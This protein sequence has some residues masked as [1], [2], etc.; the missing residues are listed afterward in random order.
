[1]ADSLEG[2]ILIGVVGDNFVAGVVARNGRIV[3]T[4]PILR[5]HMGVQA[6]MFAQLKL[7]Q[8]LVLAALA[9]NTDWQVVAAQWLKSTT[10]MARP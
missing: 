2:D 1:M 4:A 5:R 7:A 6:R 10:M 8:W 9:V 3:E